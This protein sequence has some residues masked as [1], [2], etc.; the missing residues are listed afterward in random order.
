MKPQEP[1]Y[2]GSG[3]L[4]NESFKQADCKKS[5]LFI[6]NAVHCHPRGNRPSHTHEIVNCSPYVYRELELVRPRLVIG[7]GGDA[8]RVL[9]FLYPTARKISPR[10]AAPRNLRSRTVPCVFLTEHPS[11]IKRKHNAALATEYVNS[12]SEALRWAIAKG[13]LRNQPVPQGKPTCEGMVP[14][15][16]DK[17]R[18]NL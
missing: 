9:S 5:D 14:V 18:R 7:L 16:G 4:L 12:L 17:H 3:S 10:F 15:A 8:E 13:P 1:F 6:T 11:W 2:G